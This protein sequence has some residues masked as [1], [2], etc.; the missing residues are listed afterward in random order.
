[1]PE[2]KGP[3][4]PFTIAGI[5]VPNREGFLYESA[6]KIFDAM[7]NAITTS[8]ENPT[9]ALLAY[10]TTQR[11]QTSEQVMLLHK[12]LD[13]PVTRRKNPFTEADTAIVAALTD[14]TGRLNMPKRLP[15]EDLDPRETA[16]DLQKGTLRLPRRR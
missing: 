5:E 15:P 13:I 6:R 9:D 11:I 1:M 14:I 8:E 10:L 12:A 16:P 4:Q 2:S 7:H 3:P